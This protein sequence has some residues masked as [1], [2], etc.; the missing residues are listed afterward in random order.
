[1]SRNPEYKIYLDLRKLNEILNSNKNK[2]ERLK[3]FIFYSLFYIHHFY[4]N[5]IEIGY[6]R[7]K[8][9]FKEIWKRVI[10]TIS[11][12]DNKDFIIALL[13]SYV[14]INKNYFISLFD[15]EKNERSKSMSLIIDHYEDN[16]D[17]SKIYQIVKNN[18]KIKILVKHSINNKKNIEKLFNYIDNNNYERQV[19]FSTE[20]IEVAK[21]NIL[22]GYYNEMIEFGEENFED[23]ELE[24]LKLYK[25]ELISNFGLNNTNYYIR[26]L[27][28]TKNTNSQLGKDPK[29]FK[30]YIN[31]ISKEIEY[32]ISQFYNYDLSDENYFFSK[33]YKE[34]LS[35]E[36][37][38]KN[39]DNIKKNIPLDYFIITYDENNK[40]IIDVKPSCN[41]INEIITKKIKNIL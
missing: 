31:I 7:V 22:I 30:N 33:Y 3:K 29:I 19:F 5:D 11:S 37:K 40:K 27:D 35:N 10:S 17:L 28:F 26:F 12:K 36:Q 4:G 6:K 2:K 41:L 9:Y 24:I 38:E 15:L 20:G 25:E 8:N 23:K 1:M 14:Y 21:D 34:F 32:N 13:D 16:F 18:E 39:I